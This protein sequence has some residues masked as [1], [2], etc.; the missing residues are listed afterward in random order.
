VWTCE[1]CGRAFANR[2]QTHTCAPLGDLD[3]HFARTDPA[4]RGTFDRF[5]DVARQSGPVTVLPEKTRIALQVRMS[6]AA[7]MPRR[8][9]LN[10]HLVLARTVASDRF[11]SV[12][13]FSPRNVL[14]AF[15]LTGPEDIDG[16]FAGWIREAYQVGAQEHLRS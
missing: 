7:L 2:N 10:G 14:H 3:A 5:L 15:R 1:Q 16:E 4:V 6:F 9:W 11:T 8:R 12:Q 13:V